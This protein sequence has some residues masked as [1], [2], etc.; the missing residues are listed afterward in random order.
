MY[1]GQEWGQSRQRRKDRCKLIA[2]VVG[3]VVVLTFTGYIGVTRLADPSLC[4]GTSMSQRDLCVHHGKGSE[5]LTRGGTITGGA[6]NRLHEQVT[7]NHQYGAVML[8]IIALVVLCC[9]VL[10][11]ARLRDTSSARHRL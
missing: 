10:A 8:G 6:G 2:L 4:D 3:C 9:A 1:P 5:T 7:Y 11:V